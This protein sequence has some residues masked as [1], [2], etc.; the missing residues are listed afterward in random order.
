MELFQLFFSKEIISSIV[1][2]TNLY[3]QFSI[4]KYPPEH[5]VR[6]TLEEDWYPI[7]EEELLAFFGTIFLSGIIQMKSWDEYFCLDPFS[8]QSCFTNVFSY[9]RW[10]LIKRFLYFQDPSNVMEHKLGKIYTMY[11]ALQVGFF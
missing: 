3:A 4:N 8:H 9:K 11:T 5:E 2:N 10:R 7:T 1:T 6:L